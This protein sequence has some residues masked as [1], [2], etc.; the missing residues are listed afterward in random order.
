MQPLWSH[1]LL[2]NAGELGRLAVAKATERDDASV[3]RYQELL[4]DLATRFM[5]LDPG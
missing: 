1:L 3:S 4:D 2:S 5:L